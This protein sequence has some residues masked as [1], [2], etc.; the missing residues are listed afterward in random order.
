MMPPRAHWVCVIRFEKKCLPTSP[1]HCGISLDQLDQLG[2]IR[3]SKRSVEA[4]HHATATV[5]QAMCQV[6]S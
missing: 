1:I 4:F 6:T 5:L 2:M 3:P